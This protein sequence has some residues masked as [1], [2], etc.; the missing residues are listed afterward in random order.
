MRSSVCTNRFLI[1]LFFN[2]L[3]G[4]WGRL[5]D[6]SRAGVKLAVCLALIGILLAGGIPA[7]AQTS[8]WV[9]VTSVKDLTGNI[10]LGNG[11]PLVAGHTYNVS[12]DVQVP[13]T[14]TKL[15]FNVTLN[16][17]VEPSG[18]QFWHLGT[19]QYP[20]FDASMFTSSLKSVGFEQIVGTV[21]L[22]AVFKVPTNLTE[23]T[24][25]GITLHFSNPGFQLITATQT[26]GAQPVGEAVEPVSDQSIQ[27]Y[28][29]T[30]Q[31]KSTLVSSG[32]MDPTY[33]AFMKSQLDLAQS[34][35]QAGLTEQ[36][37]LMLNTL[38]PTALPGPPNSSYVSYVFIAAILLAVLAASLGILY[39]RSRGTRGYSVGVANEITRQLASLEVM[40]GRYDKALADQLKSLREKLAEAT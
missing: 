16:S 24:D 33:S 34:M 31:A 20:G 25:N 4:R 39:L 30:Y 13:V 38:T 29:S 28:L 21:S 10:T 7:Q 2:P 1:L 14:N 27:T 23:V 12:I 8:N 32:Q 18:Y 17:L 5:G 40:A 37:T 11:E 35:F 36:A 15:K 26:G 22:S 6:G 9:T 19:P 3:S